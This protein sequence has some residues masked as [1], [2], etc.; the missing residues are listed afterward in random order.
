MKIIR[1]PYG[2]SMWTHHPLD[3][4]QPCGT[5]APKWASSIPYCVGWPRRWLAPT[6]HWGTSC[7]KL[8]WLCNWWPCWWWVQGGLLAHRKSLHRPTACRQATLPHGGRLSNWPCGLCLFRRRSIWL[9]LLDPHCAF[10]DCIYSW[11]FFAHWICGHEIRLL[12]SRQ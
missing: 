9:R 4:P 1:K 5:R 10:W 8:P 7:K 11:G 12:T 2:W 6:L 3:R